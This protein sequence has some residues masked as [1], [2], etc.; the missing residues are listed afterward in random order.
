MKV[1]EMKEL[2]KNANLDELRKLAAEWEQDERAGVHD[3]KCSILW[4][5]QG[6]RL[7]DRDHRIYTM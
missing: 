2:M 3:R 7:Y 4:C 5:R 6:C 1:S